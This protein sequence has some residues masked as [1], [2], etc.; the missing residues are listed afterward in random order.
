MLINK[1]N[2]KNNK[3]NDWKFIV[4]KMVHS[5]DNIGQHSDIIQTWVIDQAFNIIKTS[6]GELTYP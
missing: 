1:E 2:V 3:N 5:F 4:V 6:N